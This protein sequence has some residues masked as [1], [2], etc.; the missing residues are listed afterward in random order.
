[1]KSALAQLQNF[2]LVGSSSLQT[3]S[4]TLPVGK[5][6]VQRAMIFYCK[7]VHARQ[8][9]SPAKRLSSPLVNGLTRSFSSDSHSESSVTYAESEPDPDV[10]EWEADVWTGGCGGGREGIMM[11]GSLDDIHFF[12]LDD[13]EEEGAGEFEKG[14]DWRLAGITE[15]M[16]M[17][18]ERWRKMT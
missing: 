9:T 2:S 4:G 1:M 6:R 3:K 13:Y 11:P 18:M 17:M 15:V 7:N 16:S 5:I 10:G 14:K 8:M 12:G